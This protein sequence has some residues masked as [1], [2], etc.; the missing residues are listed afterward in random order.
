M[1]NKEENKKTAKWWKTAIIILAVFLF[2]LFIVAYQAASDFFPLPQPSFLPSGYF[3]TSFGQEKKGCENCARRMID[4]VYVKQ[5][6]SNLLP[7]AI[8]IDN[9]PEAGAPAGLNQANL[10]V[11]SLAEGGLT[12]FLAFFAGSEETEKIGPVRSA[13]PYFIDWA[14][15]L[16]ALYAH[17]GGSP[18]ALAKIAAERINNLDEYYQSDYFWRASGQKPPHNLFTS[19]RRLRDYLAKKEKPELPNFLPWQFKDEIPAEDR[20]KEQQVKIIFS[21]LEEVAWIYDRIG[22]NYSRQENGAPEQDEDGL[23]LT[24]KNVIIQ[25][26]KAEVVDE[27]G[28]LKIETKGEGEAVVC[29]DGSCQKGS[30]QKTADSSRTRFYSAAGE[31]IKFNAGRTWIEAAA[32]NSKVKY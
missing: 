25:Y 31:E 12:R 21:P 32:E 17:C 30:W 6:E 3:L 13:R 19:S 27:E 29:L 23:A 16:S 18:A 4:G 20:P 22:N 14:Q 1:N 10:V 26:V 28:R 9:S 5:E 8:M 11:E 2:G 7:L 15:E 24:A